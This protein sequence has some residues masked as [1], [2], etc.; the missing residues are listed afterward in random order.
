[1]KGALLVCL[2]STTWLNAIAQAAPRPGQAY[3][4]I[5]VG[6]NYSRIAP[7]GSDPAE[8]YGTS[9]VN[10]L[11]YRLGLL[12]GIRLTK[13]LSA[14]VKPALAFNDSRLGVVRPDMT[15]ERYGQS[16]TAE[17]AGHIVYRRYKGKAT[18]VL[19]A[20]LSYR[21]PLADPQSSVREM[22]TGSVGVD[23][24]VGVEKRFRNFS[25]EP[26][27]RYSH[28]LSNAGTVRGLSSVRLHTI[29]FSVNFKK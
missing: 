15:Q 7:G 3:V 11:G 6:I 20:G 19:L 21:Q 29:V 1:M 24:G 13:H 25:V 9:M 5:N 18:P 4:G 26:E 17:C 10:G 27:V 8:I 28:G 14:E 23:A 22:A 12:G 16:I 2:A